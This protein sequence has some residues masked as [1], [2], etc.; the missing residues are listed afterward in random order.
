MAT[1]AASQ[2]KGVITFS[3]SFFAQII[4]LSWSGLAR[5]AIDTSHQALTAAQLGNK[6]FIGS[7]FVDPG[8]LQVTGNFTIDTTV[9]MQGATA[10]ETV[11][12]AVGD[13]STQG[14]WAASGFMTSFEWSGPFED[15]MTFTCTIKFSGAITKT[16]GA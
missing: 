6:T 1:S 10:A 3:S 7:K 15:R 9:P 13:S 12:V 16:S 2:S 11:T 5:E 8:E 4:D 14:S